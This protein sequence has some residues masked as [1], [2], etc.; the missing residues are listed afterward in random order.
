M[1]QKEMER[2]WERL[3]PTKDC[4]IVSENKI[5]SLVRRYDGMEDPE[6]DSDERELLLFALYLESHQREGFV[7]KAYKEE[8]K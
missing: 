3:D 4:L 2:L 5:L 7:K 6:L 1:K 8:R